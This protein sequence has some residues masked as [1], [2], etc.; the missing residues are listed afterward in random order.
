MFTTVNMAANNVNI[1]NIASRLLSSPEFQQ[2]LRRILSENVETP[3]IRAAITSHSFNNIEEERASLF[4]SSSTPRGTVS[5]SASVVRTR[6]GR[7]VRREGRSFTPY[8]T[9]T[10]GSETSASYLSLSG[11]RRRRAGAPSNK[12]PYQLREVILLDTKEGKTIV[13]GIKKAELVESGKYLK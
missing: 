8:R 5:R 2:T 3:P 9:A 4:N 7:G 13:R 12:P 6:V 11:S 1:E 10:R